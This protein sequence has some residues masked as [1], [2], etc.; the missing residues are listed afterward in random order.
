MPVSQLCLPSLKELAAF[1]WETAN[2][3]QIKVLIW[4]G[5][6]ALGLVRR[7]LKTQMP[8]ARELAATLIAGLILAA[9]IAA[10]A[11]PATSVAAAKARQCTEAEKKVAKLKRPASDGAFPRIE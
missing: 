3:G 9:V 7:L 5:L 11:S 6:G 2:S 4:L 1:V 10:T 8:E